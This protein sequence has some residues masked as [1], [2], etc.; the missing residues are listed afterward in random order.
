MRMPGLLICKKARQIRGFATFARRDNKKRW[1]F[2]S[3]VAKSFHVR[4]GQ[5]HAFIKGHQNKVSILNL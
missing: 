3:S 4:R 5:V 2:F 1:C